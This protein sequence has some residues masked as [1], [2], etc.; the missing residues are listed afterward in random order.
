[1]D[2]WTCFFAMLCT[3]EQ[4]PQR[5]SWIVRHIGKLT[6]DFFE[7]LSQVADLFLFQTDGWWEFYTHHVD[8][9]R[10]LRLSFPQC[11]ERSW[12]KAG[13]PPVSGRAG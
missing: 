3:E 4:V 13:E 11:Y 7:H 12:C 5:A 1:V 8:W 6:G 9:R 10:K 2:E